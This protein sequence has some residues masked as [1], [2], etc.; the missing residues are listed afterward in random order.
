MLKTARLKPEGLGFYA[1]LFWKNNLTA[2][3]FTLR[4]KKKGEML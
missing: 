4:A 2:Q 1:I 3:I